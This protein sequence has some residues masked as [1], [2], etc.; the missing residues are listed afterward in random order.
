[1]NKGLCKMPLDWQTHSFVF[2]DGV[3]AVCFSHT[4]WFGW[5]CTREVHIIILAMHTIPP[6]KVAFF[7]A[8]LFTELKVH[9]MPFNY[10]LRVESK[11]KIFFIFMLSYYMKVSDIRCTSTSKQGPFVIAGANNSWYM[12]V[13][14]P[15]QNF[16]C[17]L[18]KLSKI[19]NLSCL[20]IKSLPFRGDAELELLDPELLELELR[21]PL[22]LDPE[23]ELRL[24]LPELP[25]L[26]E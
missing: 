8:K 13:P 3:I 15:M 7:L 12:L 6:T 16:P 17:L 18:Q 14:K 5:F 9:L 23:L 4:P 25:E 1:M 21:L 11:L 10:S 22:L 20:N 26:E 2:V 19:I 24:E